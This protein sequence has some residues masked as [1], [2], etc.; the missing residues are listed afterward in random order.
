MQAQ[1]QA[2]DAARAR[3]QAAQAEAVLDGAQ[4]EQQDKVDAARAKEAALARK[5]AELVAG[6]KLPPMKQ[7]ARGDVY[8]LAGDVF[9]GG[10]AQ[11]V[12]YTHLHACRASVHR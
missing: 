5:E 6:A 9:A 3:A 1:I 12:S 2:E 4:V 11:P 7:D 10:Q 8:T